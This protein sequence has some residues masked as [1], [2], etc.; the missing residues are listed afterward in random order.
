M[1]NKTLSPKLSL[2]KKLDGGYL[3]IKQRGSNV[4]DRKTSGG[5]SDYLNRKKNPKLNVKS[6]TSGGSKVVA[7]KLGGSKKKKMKMKKSK[8]EKKEIK[9]ISQTPIVPQ[10]AVTKP[11]TKP[12]KQPVKEPVTKPVTEPVTEPVT[13]PVKP[14]KTTGVKIQLP[15]TNGSI[16]KKRSLKRRS[17]GKRS[18]GSLTK[19]RTHDLKK[20]KR[21]SVTKTRKLSDKDVSGIQKKLKSI[22]SKTNDEIKKELE[23]QG[24]K[25]SG[26]S[27]EILKDIYMYSQLCGINIKR[28]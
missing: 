16:K 8:K 1:T 10:K 23:N 17:K 9:D 20:G 14:T 12:V 6:S 15:K 3:H 7:I 24:L 18:K 22:K 5:Y 26:K 25:L 28:E 2:S 11:V 27:P 4:K 21:I 13:K 19:R